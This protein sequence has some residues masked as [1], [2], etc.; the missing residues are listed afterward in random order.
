MNKRKRFNIISDT[1]TNKVHLKYTTSTVYARAKPRYEP[2]VV[3]RF[4]LPD[5]AEP[6]DLLILYNKCL[7]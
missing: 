6:M 5:F 3:A 2:A 4:G 7:F 1:K